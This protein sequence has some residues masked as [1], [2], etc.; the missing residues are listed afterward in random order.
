M[1]NTVASVP[2]GMRWQYW[3][4]RKYC[5]ARKAILLGLRNHWKLG[6]L[7]STT[8]LMWPICTHGMCRLRYLVLKIILMKCLIVLF[9]P[10]L[11]SAIGGILM[12]IRPQTITYWQKVELSITCNYPILPLYTI[13]GVRDQCLRVLTVNWSVCSKQKIRCSAGQ[14]KKI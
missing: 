6:I 12:L 3:Y 4:S 13:S 2:C 8:K 7:Q 1:I 9:L 10:K 14:V 11:P 5:N